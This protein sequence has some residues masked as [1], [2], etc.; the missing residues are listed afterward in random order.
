VEG[1]TVDKR[2][3]FQGKKVKEYFIG[4]EGQQRVVC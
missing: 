3:I 2:I 1:G 4:S